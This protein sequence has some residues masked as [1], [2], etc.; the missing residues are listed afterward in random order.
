MFL[1]HFVCDNRPIHLTDGIW[2]PGTGGPGGPTMF[3]LNRSLLFRERTREEDLAEAV[4]VV[5]R[6]NLRR[7][8]FPP[9]PIDGG[10]E[11][12]PRRR[13]DFRLKMAGGHG[14]D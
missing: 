5:K 2:E 10:S 4:E 7:E 14:S 3:A 12:C 6:E 1:A 11:T 13:L 8:V 9:P